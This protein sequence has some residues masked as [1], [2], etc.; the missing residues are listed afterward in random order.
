MNDNQNNT[1]FWDVLAGV[2]IRSFWIGAIFLALWF[3]FIATG[4]EW[5]YNFHSRIFPINSEMFYTLH[6][7]G[8]MILK[9]AVCVFFL[10][11]YIAIKWT[12]AGRNS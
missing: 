7:A 6:Y 4:S 12:L 5:I 1:E 8:M 10:I 2:L 3:V 11:P 9:S